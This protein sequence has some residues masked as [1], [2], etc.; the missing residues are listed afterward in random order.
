MKKKAI[1]SFGEK[2]AADY[3]QSRGYKILEF[4]FSSKFGEIDLIAEEDNSLVFIEVKTR[5]NLNYGLP[6]TAVNE[7]KLNNIK[8]AAMI[9]KETHPKLSESYRIDVV[10]IILRN[11]RKT[12]KIKLYKN[13]VQ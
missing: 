11:G 5:Q 8:M 2:I 7:K 10:S 13:I 12:A 3:L 6:E 4:N 9:Y 1:G